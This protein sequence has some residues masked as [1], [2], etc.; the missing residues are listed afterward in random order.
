MHAPVT[1]S[2]APCFEYDPG[3]PVMTNRDRITLTQLEPTSAHPYERTMLRFSGYDREALELFRDV[4][5][6]KLRT[7][8]KGAK[9]WL[10]TDSIYLEL[11]LSLVHEWVDL[12][13]MIPYYTIFDDRPAPRTWKTLD[14]GEHNE[15]R[16]A[17]LSF[18]LTRW[19]EAPHV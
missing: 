6:S 12:D 15:H 9:T 13:N 19:N 11:F 3:F 7:Y 14:A 17:A 2:F 4:I 1:N 5:P 8:V 10:I 18:S 16:S